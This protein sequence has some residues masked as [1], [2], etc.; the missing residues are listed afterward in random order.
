MYK[1]SIWRLGVTNPLT[2]WR[3]KG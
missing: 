3:Y 1:K 2:M